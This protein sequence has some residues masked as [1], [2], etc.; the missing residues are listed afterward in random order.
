[1]LLSRQIFHQFQMLQMIEDLRK[2]LF[3]CMYFRANAGDKTRGTS[4]IIDTARFNSELTER[5]LFNLI[6]GT[7]TK[8]RMCHGKEEEASIAWDNV[9][10]KSWHTTNSFSSNL[11]P[12][13][14]T[15]TSRTGVVYC[16]SLPSTDL[17]LLRS[18][19]IYPSYL[20]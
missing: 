13:S 9:N 16:S 20:C 14:L 19:R 6:D 10:N 1:M 8:E 7:K 18:L 17:R 4:K 11:S 2:Y 12:F 15:L 5:V 3:R